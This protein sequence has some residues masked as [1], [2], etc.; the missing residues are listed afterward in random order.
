M[1]RQT[2]TFDGKKYDV[3]AKTEAELAVKIAMKKRD[4]KEGHVVIGGNMTVKQWSKQWVETYKKGIIGDAWLAS[5]QSIIDTAIIPT[6][7]H[8][9][10]KDVRS[11]HIQR[12][13]NLCAGKSQSYIHKVATILK[14]MFSVARKNKIILDDPTE[15][16]APPTGTV[17]KRRAI[18][19][20]E[21]KYILQLAEKHRAGLFLKIILYCGLRPGEVAALTWKDIDI[22]NRIIRVERALKRDGSIGSPKSAAGI[23]RVPIPAALLDDLNPAGPFENVCTQVS[24]RPHTTKSI[25]QMW[26]SFVYRLNIEMGCKTFKGGLIPPY[27]VADDLVM[28]CLRHTY[29]TD[30]QS[31]GVPINVAKELMGHSTIAMTA[32]IY[33]HGSD[34]SFD[35]AAEALDILNN[36]KCGKGCGKKAEKR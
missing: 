30:L 32:Q 23:R 35:A 8:V 7:G 34:E 26:V 9:R 16:M 5:M 2:F 20:T 13:L 11:I 27:R 14:E 36:N 12:T 25:R 22:G 19:E 15:T 3:R 31:A 29:C 17:N 1:P 18:T 21:R 4:I 28:Y 10:M 24:L 6:L 33:T